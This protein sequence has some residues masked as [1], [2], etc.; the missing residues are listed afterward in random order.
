MEY[1]D[2]LDILSVAY[3][4]ETSEDSCLSTLGL[5]DNLTGKKLRDVSLEMPFPEVCVIFNTERRS[6]IIEFCDHGIM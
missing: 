2:E 5:Y 6:S 4:T 3:I 1:E